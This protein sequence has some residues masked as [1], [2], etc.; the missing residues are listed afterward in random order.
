[1]SIHNIEDI[2]K[3]YEKLNVKCD[4]SYVHEPTFESFQFPSG[5]DNVPT[6]TSYTTNEYDD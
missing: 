2:K 5:Y 1:M 4:Q 6:K 3:V